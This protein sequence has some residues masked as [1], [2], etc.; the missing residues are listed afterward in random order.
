MSEACKILPAITGEVTEY[1][2]SKAFSLN[3]YAQW[4]ENPNHHI[5]DG[6]I[7][8]IYPFTA[9]PEELRVH[10]KM[11]AAQA[12]AN[13]TNRM[14]KLLTDPK[15]WGKNVVRAVG[16]FDN[17]L[18]KAMES[19]MLVTHGKLEDLRLVVNP[20]ST[21]A[22]QVNPEIPVVVEDTPLVRGYHEPPGLRKYAWPDDVAVV[23]Y[24]N[25]GIGA[26]FDEDN[27]STCQIVHY[28]P[29]LATYQGEVDNYYNLDQSVERINPATGFM[30]TLR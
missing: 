7:R 4:M 16:E 25:G 3:E 1:I 11:N 30:I 12:M 27:P 15:T 19:L 29:P 10:A 5:F 20:E 6:M 26:V 9:G 2:R 22:K 23:L 28:G 21:L 8:R 18:F 13:R 14:A 17:S 24:R